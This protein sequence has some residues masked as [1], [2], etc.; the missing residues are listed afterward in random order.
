MVCWDV[1]RVG[2]TRKKTLQC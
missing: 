1:Y 2:L